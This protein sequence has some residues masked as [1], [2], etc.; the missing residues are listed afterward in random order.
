MAAIRR[1][2][3]AATFSV[4]ALGRSEYLSAERTSEPRNRK[5]GVTKNRN[6]GKGAWA[7][8]RAAWVGS[9]YFSEQH[10]YEC[11]YCCGS[12]RFLLVLLWVFIVT[13]VLI[14]T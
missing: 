2:F 9:G 10:S 13:N 5:S 7:E 12:I 6:L 4:L 8:R 1:A 3:V 14:S 11:H